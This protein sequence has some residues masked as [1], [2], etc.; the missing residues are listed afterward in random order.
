MFGAG[1]GAE[2]VVIVAMFI[3]LATDAFVVSEG[4]S[5]A[6]GAS[7]PPVDHIPAPHVPVPDSAH[8]RTGP[9]LELNACHI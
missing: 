4:C 7:D 6:V 5:D 3:S 8:T 1:A 2:A 9:D